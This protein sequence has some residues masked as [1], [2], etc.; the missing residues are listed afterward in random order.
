MYVNTGRILLCIP[1]TVCS[2]VYMYRLTT[3]RQTERTCI[4]Y[5]MCNVPCVLLGSYTTIPYFDTYYY[6]YM[7]YSTTVAYTTVPL[8]TFTYLDILLGLFIFAN[9]KPL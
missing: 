6:M 7:Y 2:C 4:I 3:D 8:H 9:S 1:C 5:M